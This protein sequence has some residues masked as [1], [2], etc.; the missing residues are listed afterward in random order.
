MT[1]T[2][3]QIKAAQT[4]LSEMIAKFEKQPA[5][6]TTCTVTAPPLNP[7]ELWVGVII[8][9][10]G[11]KRHHIILLPGAIQDST[12]QKSMD[13]AASIGGDLPNRCESALLFA[14]LK[15]EFQPEW[16]WTNEQYA[17]GSG[18]AWNQSFGN[19]YQYDHGKSFEGRARAVR[20]ILITYTGSEG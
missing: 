6:F 2:I 15:E 16:Y 19:G 17:A 20:R 8:S 9:A 5:P 14:T 3:E 18:Y 10:N 13:W 4:V 7:G 11:T 12:W 1:I